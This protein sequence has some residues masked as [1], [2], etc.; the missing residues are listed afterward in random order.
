[1]AKEMAAFELV[2][3]VVGSGDGLVQQER[4]GSQLRPGDRISGP[5]L[6]A[7]SLLSSAKG[8]TGMDADKGGIGSETVLQRDQQQEDA[9]GGEQ[10]DQ[11]QKE[12]ER[13]RP[14]EMQ[15]FQEF[16][17]QKEADQWS[18]ICSG[19]MIRLH[20]KKRTRLFNPSQRRTV[21]VNDLGINRTTVLFLDDGTRLVKHDE[22]TSGHRMPDGVHG[23]QWKS[24]TFF[25]LKAS[26]LGSREGIPEE[27]EVTYS[28]GPSTTA[29]TREQPRETLLSGAKG[30]S[31]MSMTGATSFKLED[32]GGKGSGLA[33]EISPKGKGYP[34]E[35][36]TL[37][38]INKRGST[39]K[40][41][42]LGVGDDGDGN[43]SDDG[44]G[45][46]EFVADETVE[47]LGS[48]LPGSK[49]SAGSSRP[50][51]RSFAVLA[52]MN[53]DRG[54]REDR[55]PGKPKAKRR[56]AVTLKS[57]ED[58]G[59]PGPIREVQELQDSERKVSLRPRR[60]KGGRKE[61]EKKTCLTR[62]RR[63]QV[64]F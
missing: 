23:R 19:W 61:P 33:P 52:E 28:S 44:H 2:E 17:Y 11:D 43:V 35:G 47:E 62:Q 22:W 27:E 18:G 50:A 12:V 13:E 16:P 14:W 9:D 54:E 46:C 55:T 41:T 40:G 49:T 26:K 42:S 48:L 15:M 6:R 36:T 51:L 39:A 10:S 8:A 58:R 32:P 25:K 53:D 21:N 45:S 5:R 29:S 56:P 7:M 3:D 30:A 34:K 37:P 20:G 24:F 64:T 31:A 4:L 38:K 57:A 1:M 63:G 60:S 59:L